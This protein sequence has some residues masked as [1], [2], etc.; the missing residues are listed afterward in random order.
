MQI[1]AFSLQRLASLQAAAASENKTIKKYHWSSLLRIGLFALFSN[2]T[3]AL[4]TMSAT[5]SPFPGVLK[6]NVTAF[7]HQLPAELHPKHGLPPSSS[8]VMLSARHIMGERAWSLSF[9]LLRFYPFWF[10]FS[11]LFVG[12]K[13]LCVVIFLN[14]IVRDE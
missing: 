10:C 5:L 13:D 14:L 1:L 11:R 4:A 2:T 8:S 6:L 9:A 3:S 7:V 12:V